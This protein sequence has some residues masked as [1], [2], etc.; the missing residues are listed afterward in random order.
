MTQI[1]DDKLIEYIDHPEQ[2][3]SEAI[4]TAQQEIAA[5]GGIE[6]LKAR[7]LSA[8][9]LPQPPPPSL[10]TAG[11]DR[12]RD[13]IRLAAILVSIPLAF[14]VTYLALGPLWMTIIKHMPKEVLQLQHVSQSMNALAP[15]SALFVFIPLL[16]FFMNKIDDLLR[17]AKNRCG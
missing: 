4:N 2:F 14:L 5:R 3:T 11:N 17:K 1:R 12:P 9:H 7:L 13:I 16:V 6:A 10:L 8:Q 15:I